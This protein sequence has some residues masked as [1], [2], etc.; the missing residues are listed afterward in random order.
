VGVR[1]NFGVFLDFFG[2]NRDVFV[3]FVKIA[4]NDRDAEC[5]DMNRLNY[6]NVEGRRQVVVASCQ[7]R[8]CADVYGFW[9]KGYC[10]EDSCNGCNRVYRQSPLQ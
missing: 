3:D 10:Y 1:R 8:I 5:V 9:G 2:I 7:G 4:G 6:R